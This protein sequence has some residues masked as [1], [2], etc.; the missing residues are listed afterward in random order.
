MP[1]LPRRPKSKGGS[2]GTAQRRVEEPET[3]QGGAETPLP[4]RE[5]GGADRPVQSALQPAGQVG[6]FGELPPR[7]LSIAGVRQECSRNELAPSAAPG[8][9]PRRGTA[10]YPGPP[11]PRRSV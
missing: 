10:P 9:C 4:D 8:S 7:P 6:R 3:P 11:H 2:H 5:T 1:P